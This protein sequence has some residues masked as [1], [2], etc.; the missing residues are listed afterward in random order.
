MIRAG[1]R[2][3]EELAALA[4]RLAAAGIEQAKRFTWAASARG[5]LETYESLLG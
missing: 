2:C 3:Y 5:L 4:A 1:C